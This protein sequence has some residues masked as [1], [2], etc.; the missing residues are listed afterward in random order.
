[1][2]VER[3][4]SL[5]VLVVLCAVGF[6]YYTVVFLVIEQGLSVRTSAGLM[7]S[8]V[9]SAFTLMALLSYALAIFRDPGKV[10]QSYRPDIEDSQTPLHEVKRKGG[11]LRYC[12]KC[13]HYKPP[14]A[15]HCRV[16]KRC[17]LRMDHHCIWINNC[18]GHKN[19]KA[20]FLFVF[21]VVLACSYALI[22]LAGYA[23]NVVGDSE[24]EFGRSRAPP[25]SSFIATSALLKVLCATI[26]VPLSIALIV[27]LS[28]HIYLLLCNKTTIEY[29]EGVRAHWLAEKAGQVYRHPYDVGA[30]SNL[31]MILGPNLMTWMCPTVVG[32]IDSGLHFQTFYHST[33][34][35]DTNE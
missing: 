9:F 30:F 15:H 14:R 11:D 6:V 31:T 20:F 13:G 16:C 27:L 4:F 3:C 32:H 22:L 26:L 5:P 35:G 7:N 34:R 29:H 28:W 17:V 8:L 12:Q 18:V 10:P 19:Y 1:M 24:Q 23:I 21:Y 33:F 25:V 2:D